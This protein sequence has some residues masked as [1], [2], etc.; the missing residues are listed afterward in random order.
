[1]LNARGI[2]VITVAL[3]IAL[4]SA[5]LVSRYLRQSVPEEIMLITAATDIPAGT[6]LTKKNMK[7]VRWRKSDS[8]RGGFSNAGKLVG[9]M[10]AGNIHQGE[11]IHENRLL[12]KAGGI[13]S[14]YTGGIAP[15][16]RT[17][18]IETDRVSGLH[19]LLNTG[20]F[21]DVLAVSSL[22]KEKKTRIS[23]V[24][25]SRIKVFVVKKKESSAKAEKSKK[26]QGVTLVLSPEDARILAVSRGAEL[27]LIKRN[28]SDDS[29]EESEGT[30]YSVSMGPRSMSRLAVIEQEK[31]KKFND[32]MEKGQRAV[33][34]AFKD[35]DGICGFIRPGNSVD[36]IAIST[37]GDISTE[38]DAPGA[39]AELLATTKTAIIILQNIKVLAVDQEAGSPA[40]I[41]Q[42]GDKKAMGVSPEEKPGYADAKD[43]E[44]NGFGPRN[45]AGPER[46]SVIGRITL[47]LSPEESEKLVV[48]Y[49]SEQIKFVLR[50]YNDEKIVKT[51]G[52]KLVESFWGKNDNHVIEVYR[53][54]QEWGMEFDRDDLELAT[55]QKTDPVPEKIQPV[56]NRGI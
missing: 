28:P 8:P 32:R 39:K 56:G 47:L 40:Q 17:I 52:H 25:L 15:G 16:M 43:G 4:V 37:A 29:K 42:K 27:R 13:D 6:C 31:E 10:T 41:A 26:K 7:A 33:T 20:D 46:F 53:G 34:V 3:V 12:P 49:N 11:P 35:D 14:G 44:K 48:A 36:V 50:N 30:V 23:R 9:R 45:L 21:V 2:I 38:G 55:Q 18:S 54:N 24:I 19:G 51:H 1:M 22:D 5:T